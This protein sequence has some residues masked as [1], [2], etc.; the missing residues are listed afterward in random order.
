MRFADVRWFCLIW[1]FR[2]LFLLWLLPRQSL[3]AAAPNIVVILAD[4]LG[5]ADLGI[6]GGQDIPTP[7]IDS[8]GRRGVRFTDAYANGSFCT[9]TRAALISCRYQQRYGIED[10]GG[11]LPSQAVTLPQRLK[12]AGY[13]TA[14]VGKWHLGTTAGYRPNER[15]FDT[16][17][18]F[19]GGGHQYIIQA[20]GGGEYNAPILRNDQDAGEQR[21]LT[22][23]F[24]EEAAAWISQQRDARQPFFLYLAFNAVHTPLQAIDKYKARFP[25][26]TDPRRQ[27]YAAMLSAM[28]DAV[29]LVLAEL[30]A[31]GK[32]G[33]TLIV[34]SSDNGGPTTR[35]AVNGSSNVP[36][37]GSKCETWEGG[38]RVPL[39]MEW[40]GRIAAG[41]TY[42]QPVISF[43]ISA[44]ALAAGQADSRRI[45]GIDLLPYLSGKQS[46]AP[47]EALF[48]RS[49]TMSNNYA[50]RQGAWKFVH[51][52]EGD[53][54][55]GPKQTPARD[56]LFNLAED[57][58]EQHDLADKY[59]EKLVALK[60]LWEAWSAEVDA[61]C[62]G[63][64]LQPKFGRPEAVASEPARRVRKKAPAAKSSKNPSSSAAAAGSRPQVLI[65]GDSISIGY[66]SMVRDRLAGQAEVHR[67]SANCGDTRAGL[68]NL[69]LWLGDQSW[70]V[71][72]FNWGLHDLCYRHPDSKVQGNR[73]KV[74][75]TQAVPLGDYATNL[76]ELVQRLQKTGAT[77]IWASTSY[78]PVGEA[79]RY[80]GDER[81]YNA[82]AEKIMKAHGI[83]IN[84]LHATT[85][86]FPATLF[87]N[88][89]DVHYLPEGYEKLANQVADKI[90][91]AL[92]LSP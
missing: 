56:M 12:N 68:K 47:H 27:T 37:R 21:Y 86:N 41:S 79:G 50:V 77:L 7:H 44:T 88:P 67:P 82:V 70:D 74:R 33:E 59:P 92:K 15:G 63:M 35:N 87:K 65:L 58:G 45:D 10:L 36:L 73:D 42:S 8:I 23:A 48:W 34:F 60:R 76:Q 24:G 49:R 1:S 55:P 78:V 71:I 89:G 85:A 91:E 43:D 11:P 26:L 4:D 2:V 84:D 54:V 80:V 25:Q 46:G 28:D 30:E 39:L 9:P 22:D 66:T 72:H 62:V 53:A 40:Q 57:I 17:F 31:I 64:G 14:M 83:A 18:G 16:F 51:S 29:G 52:T 5:Y 38:I 3:T 75:G 20:G 69:E 13:R 6:H 61:D 81:R 90:R 19:L 32:R